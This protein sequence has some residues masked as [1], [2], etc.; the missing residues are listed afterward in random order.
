MIIRWLFFLM[1][2]RITGLE[3]LPAQ[4]PVILAINHESFWD[5]VLVCCALPRQ[6]RFMAKESLFRVPILGPALRLFGTFPVKR[7]HGDTSAIRNSLK[8]LQDG[9]VLGVFPEGTRSKNG[10]MQKALPGVVLLMEKSKAVVLPV[11][12]MG[13][14]KLLTQGWHKIQ[15]IVG[16]PVQIEQLQPPEDVENRREWIAGR[17]MLEI[18]KL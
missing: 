2:W 16:D 18:G 8:V 12:V 14:K 5:P 7:G 17:I 6:V 9:Q 11:K 15:V 10:E 3:K 13:G 4:G 1:R